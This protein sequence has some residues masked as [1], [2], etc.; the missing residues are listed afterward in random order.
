MRLSGL[1]YNA[2]HPA[3]GRGDPPMPEPPTRPRPPWTLVVL[4]PLTAAAY[5]LVRNSI[6]YPLYDVWAVAGPVG[7]IGGALYWHRFRGLGFVPPALTGAGAIGAWVLAAGWTTEAVVVA[8]FLLGFAFTRTALYLERSP[9]GDVVAPPASLGRR[10]SPV[11]AGVVLTCEPA[12]S[13]TGGP[14]RTRS[15]PAWFAATAAFLA[16][17][18]WLRLFRP[19][20]ELASEPLLWVMYRVRPVPGRGWRTIPAAR[21]VP[22]RRQPRL[23]ARPDVPGEGAAAADHPDD[24]QPVLRPAGDP[25][26][27]ADG[28]GVI[29]VPE[30][31]LKQDAPG[32]SGGDRRPRPRRVRGDLPRRGT[33]G[34]A[35][36][37]R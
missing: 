14:S 17:F 25:L 28:V 5:G 32:D 31:A 2:G 23:L 33:C 15:S 22:R 12:R 6:P 24:D 9:P 3:P 18:A 11:G 16:G 19:A 27:D 20:F 21:A 13:R 7:L 29:R 8:S 4:L 36:R 37:S 1:R 10:I 35:R 34:G 26:A 30:K